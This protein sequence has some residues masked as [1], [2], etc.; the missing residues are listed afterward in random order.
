[1]VVG[2][3]LQVER[4]TYQLLSDAGMLPPPVTRTLLGEVDDEVDEL[5][6]HGPRHRLGSG[7]HDQRRLARMLRG[8]DE[9]LPA[10]VGTDRQALSYAE[11]TARRLA[12]RRTAEALDLFAELPAVRPETVRD[13]RA[14]F[15]R[16][17]QAA[18]DRLASLD[19]RDADTT[20]ALRDRQAAVLAEA[21]AARALHELAEIGLLPERLAEPGAG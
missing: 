1:V 2:R 8:L 19:E 11:A 15:E 10:P 3:G 12:A 21:E 5:A 18:V 9:R 14:V 20:R 17:E 6:L 13:A 4:T 16:W 7:R